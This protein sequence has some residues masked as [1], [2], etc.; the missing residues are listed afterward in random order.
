MPAL[1]KFVITVILGNAI[2]NSLIVD[3]ITATC[4]VT[5]TLMTTVLLC[6]LA[7]ALTY[8]LRMLTGL[9]MAIAGIS[10]GA[11]LQLC[12]NTLFANYSYEQDVYN[13]NCYAIMKVVSEPENREK[14][15]RLQCSLIDK[16][17]KK[18][19]KV[20]VYLK[21]NNEDSIYVPQQGNILAIK[22]TIRKIPPPKSDNDFN[23]KKYCFNNNIGYISYLNKDDYMIIDSAKTDNIMTKIYVLRDKLASVL[24][25]HAPGDIESSIAKAILLGVNELS[26]ET[27]AS[28]SSSGAIHVLCVS[29]LHVSTIYLLLGYLLALVKNKWFTGFCAPV[30]ILCFLWM[31]A[32][33]TGFSPS[34]SRAA[35]MLSFIVIG[36]ACKRKTNIINTLCGSALLLIFINPDIIF[37]IGFQLSYAAVLGIVLFQT[38]INNFMIKPFSKMKKLY[39]W[40]PAKIIGIISVSVAVQLLLSPILLYYFG[41]F[42]NYFLL[43]NI[44]VIPLASVII[45][46]GVSLLIL[47]PLPLIADVTGQLFYGFVRLLNNAVK[48]VASIPNSVSMV[49]KI[50]FMIV[51]FCFVFLIIFKLILNSGMTIKNINAALTCICLLLVYLLI[52]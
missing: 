22:K 17:A 51:L 3:D 19:P 38:P 13:E 32:A 41:S 47:S 34:V 2:C 7:N 4:C 15:Y 27:R 44:I 26:D 9:L 36:N 28:F 30:I 33:V 12:D 1:P 5:S 11:C 20:I 37:N 25:K 49:N 45:Y 50:D 24:Q 6:R 46:L 10:L 16:E 29:G 18:L 52:P 42:S 43:T 23:Y 48:A 39:A 35:F 21:K 31:Y 14:N 40:L 8:K